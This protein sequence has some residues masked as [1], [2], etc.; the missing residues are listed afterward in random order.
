MP[1]A[2]LWQ[3]G[4][5]TDLGVLPGEEDSGASAINNLGQIVGSS[6][7]IDPETYEVTSRSFIYQ[8]GVMTALPVP[9]SESYAGDINDSGVVVGTM[10]APG[11]VGNYRAYIYADG[12]VTNL[13]NLIPPGSGLD[14]IYATGINNA[15]QIVGVAYDS[16]MSYHA[17][18]PDSGRAGHARRQ[19]RGRVGDRRPCGNTDRQLHRHALRG[20]QP[21]SHGVLQHGQ[22]NRRGGKRLPVRIRDRDVR[23]RPDDQDDLRAG[24]RR[25]HGR[26]RTRPSRSTLAWRRG[27]PCSATRRAWA[28]SSTT[29]RGSASTP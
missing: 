24:E 4:V 29:S 21:A 27:T 5:M 20:V 13:N 6:G 15:G 2:F 16:R 1:H 9:S 3:N 25:P 17:V 10:R 14:L 26:A 19:H 11:G 28:R 7:R 8:D 23:R 22:R 18:P 12:V